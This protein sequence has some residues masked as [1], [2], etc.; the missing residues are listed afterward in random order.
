MSHSD[1]ALEGEVPTSFGYAEMFERES[2]GACRL[3]PV[4]GLGSNASLSPRPDRG[5]GTLGGERQCQQ[6]AMQPPVRAFK[7]TL[8]EFAVVGDR[9]PDPDR[10]R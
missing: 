7:N 10:P 1:R 5:M 6:A 9:V 2:Y 8:Q 3:C 4:C